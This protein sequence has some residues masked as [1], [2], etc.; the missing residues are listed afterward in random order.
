VNVIGARA[1]LS[2]DNSALVASGGL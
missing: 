2:D 1:G